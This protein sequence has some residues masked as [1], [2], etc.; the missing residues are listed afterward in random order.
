[1]STSALTLPVKLASDVQK[2][3][4]GDIVELFKLDATSIGGS[5]S[6]FHAGTNS[7][8]ISVVFGGITYVPFP[9]E[10]T[11]FERSSKGT[12]ATPSMK[13]ANVTGLIGSL[14]KTLD[15]LVGAKVV[16]VRTFVKYLD[17]IN[18]PGGVNTS[19]DAL[20]KFPDEIWFVSRKIS[21]DRLFVEF[22]LSSSMDVQGVLL[23]RRQV[24]ANTC[25]WKYRGPECGYTGT[26][27]F[28]INDVATT[29]SGDVCSKRLGG[30]KLRHTTPI[31]L[32]VAELPYGGFPGVGRY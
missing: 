11:G 5:I 2:L 27:Y 1:M 22:E 6:Y 30:C 26:L 29:S 20:A 24:I 13:V 25:I 14:C 18:F 28:D 4:P 23:P 21:E 15:D 16:R 32:V 8:M 9:V 10:A 12:L 17:A 7:L 3:T 31:T 19:A